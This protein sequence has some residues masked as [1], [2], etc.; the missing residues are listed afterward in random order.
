MSVETVV[1]HEEA[2]EDAIDVAKEALKRQQSKEKK[3]KKSRTYQECG[4]GPILGKKIVQYRKIKVFPFLRFNNLY[5]SA[6]R[7]T[8]KKI[9][10]RKNMS[11]FKIVKKKI[12][13][14]PNILTIKASHEA[15]LGKK[16]QMN[17]T[18]I[19]RYL[20]ML[21][22]S[23]MNGKV[24]SLAIPAGKQMLKLLNYDESASKKFIDMFQSLTNPETVKDIIEINK[25]VKYKSAFDRDNEIIS[26]LLEKHSKHHKGRSYG[27]H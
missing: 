18:A 14:V 27:G 4:Y 10:E 16:K 12:S 20:V 9:L 11:E 13:D 3:S 17:P 22:L 1:N 2:M 25:N 6:K 26:K 24:I 8:A 7:S 15:Q 19:H 5:D 23:K 21:T